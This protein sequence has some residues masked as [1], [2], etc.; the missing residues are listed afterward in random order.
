MGV[1][2]TKLTGAVGTLEGWDDIQR[3]L[4][5]LYSDPWE[6]HEV[7]Q[8]QVLTLRLCWGNHQD[9]LGWE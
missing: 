3:D 1:D 8:A 6:S 7:M 4:D 9:H 2:D 5:K